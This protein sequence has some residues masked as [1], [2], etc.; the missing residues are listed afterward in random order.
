MKYKDI[1]ILVPWEDTEGKRNTTRFRFR[2]ET[3]A[4]D[5]VA[6]VRK[7]F[8]PLGIILSDTDIEHYVLNWSYPLY[9]GEA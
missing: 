3:E 2:G 4:E 6:S 8:M 7:A 9:D 5:I 1:G